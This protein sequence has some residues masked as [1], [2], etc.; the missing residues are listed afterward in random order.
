MRSA[1]LIPNTIAACL[2]ALALWGLIH[3]M[4]VA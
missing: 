2:I 4:G 3:L 1:D